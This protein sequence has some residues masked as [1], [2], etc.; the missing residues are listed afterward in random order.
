V[1]LAPG[2]AARVVAIGHIRISPADLPTLRQSLAGTFSA[3]LSSSTLKQADDQTVAALAA[4]L[5]ASAQTVGTDEWGVVACPCYPGRK[6]LTEIIAKFRADG[7]WSVT[8]HYIPHA[9]LHSMPGLLTQALKLHGPAVGVGG[10]P[11]AD[12]DALCAAAA[13]LAGGDAPGVWLVRTTPG[14]ALAAAVEPAAGPGDAD[15]WATIARL[16]GAAA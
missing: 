8:P 10:T 7:P 14:E 15:A 13:W 1:C 2:V 3:T 5:R 11:G 6:R 9:L 12:G 16:A 4:M